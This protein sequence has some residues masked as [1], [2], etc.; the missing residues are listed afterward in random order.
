MKINNV[1]PIQGINKY[2]NI[3]QNEQDVKKKETKKDQLSISSEAEAM[4][5][6]TENISKTAR[7]NEVKSLINTG[8]YNIDSKLVAEKI[9]DFY[10]K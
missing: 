1:N 10:K 4:L 9:I 7:I 8:T 2:Q 5:N 6:K 3:N